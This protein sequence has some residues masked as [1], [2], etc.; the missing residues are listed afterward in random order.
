[1][2]LALGW[3]CRSTKEGGT[4]SPTGTGG[5]VLL[6][7][8]LTH[9]S[10]RRC[11]RSFTGRPITRSRW[12][13][14]RSNDQLIAFVCECTRP[15]CYDNSSQQVTHR[16]LVSGHLECVKGQGQRLLLRSIKVG[17]KVGHDRIG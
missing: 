16:P 11:W 1:M 8:S 10:S 6:P 17:S 9:L 13:A 14:C 4:S 2:R 12:R 7:E 3:C 15:S 5:T